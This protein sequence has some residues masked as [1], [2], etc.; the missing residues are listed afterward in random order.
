MRAATP[1]H[2]TGNERRSLR[3]V[4]ILVLLGSLAGAIAGY[5][6][7][8]G[9][10]AGIARMQGD[11]ANAV[12]SESLQANS[13]G[14][15]PARHAS[16]QAVEFLGSAAQATVLVTHTLPTGGLSVQP[17]LRFYV[18][19]PK[20]WQRS[21]P[22]AGFWGAPETLDT[23]HLHFVYGQRDQSIVED[24]AP[25]AEASYML[26]CRATGVAPSPGGLTPI[27]IVGG[28]FPFYAQVGDGRI[29]LT[30]PSLYTVAVQERAS[31]LQQVVD[32]ALVDQVLAAAAARSPAKTQWQPLV[33]A[34]GAWLK[35]NTG[36]GRTPV[37][38][39]AAAGRLLRSPL[40][41]TWRLAD[42]QEDVLR[43]DTAAQTLVVFT[44]VTDAERQTQRRAAAEQLI[45]YIAGAYGID[46]LPE[47]L[48][49]F[50][51]YEDWE[52]LA[53]AVLDVSAAELEGGWHAAMRA[54][55][56]WGM[57]Q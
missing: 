28:Y 34:F 1:R 42:L 3:A 12:T 13:L 31:V 11:V 45:G 43:Y 53:P 7:W 44:L 47:L 32:V 24:V 55:A 41:A 50:A 17:E 54:G 46:V 36:R 9:A 5:G 2:E 57:T 33:Q 27:E 25:G 23:A 20:G 35:A 21:D 48:Q 6:V 30:S 10:Q 51:E 49:G 22:I 39:A 15:T 18:Q 16:V 4:V 29:R 38:A 52:E 8:H 26:L 19:T 14:Q 40:L 37:D 56:P